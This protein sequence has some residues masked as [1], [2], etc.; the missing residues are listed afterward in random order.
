MTNMQLAGRLLSAPRRFF[1]DLAESPRFAL[2]MWLIVLC[3]V[4]LVF[5]FYSVVDLQ[6]IV[7]QQMQANPNSARMTEAQREAAARF[8]TRGFLISAALVSTVVFIYV[9]RL[10]EAL[11]YRIGGRATGHA[12]SYRQWF[13]FAWWTSTPGLIGILPSIIT[14][15]FSKNGQID[16]AALQP[17]SLNALFFHLQPA[18]PGYQVLSQVSVLVLASLAL[19]VFGVRVWSKRSWLYSTVFTLLPVAVIALVVAGLMVRR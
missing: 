11:Y 2:P 12:R 17:L 9:I 7:D 4:G 13:A 15:A 8:M 3:T 19:T 18:D 10:L 5:W 16:P 6:W 1:D 14:L